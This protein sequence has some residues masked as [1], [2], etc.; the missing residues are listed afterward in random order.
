MIAPIAAAFSVL[1]RI[2]LWLAYAALI[3]MMALTTADAFMRYGM[4]R[5]LL[6]IE[7]LT[8]EVFMPAIVY[9][10][11]THVYSSGGH[12]RMTIVSDQLPE[13]VQRWLFTLYDAAGMV[14]MAAIAYGVGSRA[15]QSYAFN[16]YST[17]PIGYL[18]APC[19]AIVAVGAGLLALRMAG[20]VL[21]GRQPTPA[22]ESD[23]S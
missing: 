6:G 15:L 11:A 14:L 5:P 19:F 8:A 23:L 1:E 17:N 16:E 7:G 10:A 3:A 22:A 2:A 13:A 4:G 18:L 12:I 21:T 20:S 9:L